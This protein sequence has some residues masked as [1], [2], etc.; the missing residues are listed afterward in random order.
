MGVKEPNSHMI[1]RSF[2]DSPVSH[3]LH[4]KDTTTHGA[5][6]NKT[7]IVLVP[8]KKTANETSSS[9]SSRRRLLHKKTAH[10]FVRSFIPTATTRFV[11]NRRGAS[12]ARTTSC[13]GWWYATRRPQS[14]RQ[15]PA[16]HASWRSYEMLC[17][18]R[19]KKMPGWQCTAGA[20]DAL[21]WSERKKEKEGYLC[22][23]DGTDRERSVWIS[24]DA[25]TEGR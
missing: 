16:P 1:V 6:S 22:G 18:M 12:R 8:K 2:V 3:P 13:C 11:L 7:C 9:S 25:S 24:N 5:W 15:S 20:D 21:S 17:E 14:T 23:Y 4:S 19:T 10:P